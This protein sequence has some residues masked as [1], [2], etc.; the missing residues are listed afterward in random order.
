MKYNHKNEKEYAEVNCNFDIG[1]DSNFRLV[2]RS[3]EEVGEISGF[4]KN[5][6]DVDYITINKEDAQNLYDMLC[7]SIER[8]KRT[9]EKM[10]T[11]RSLVIRLLALK[12]LLI[13]LVL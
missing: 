2:M 4:K 6:K 3:M 10:K 9:L 13:I 11:E 1:L 12:D 5:F 8:L 7:D